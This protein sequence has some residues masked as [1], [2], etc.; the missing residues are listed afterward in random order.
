[1]VDFFVAWIPGLI[2]RRPSSWNRVEHFGRTGHVH[3]RGRGSSNYVMHCI[4]KAPRNR[5]KRL[6]VLNC[7]A[8]DRGRYEVEEWFTTFATQFNTRRR[9]SRLPGA[10]YIASRKTHPQR[11]RNRPKYSRRFRVALAWLDFHGATLDL[12]CR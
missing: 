4:Y 7:A 8:N 5:L 1:M 11:R 12:R 6:L 3:C 10:F 9:F 2:S